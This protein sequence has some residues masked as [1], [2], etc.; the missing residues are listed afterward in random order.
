MRAVFILT[1]S[2]LL[3]HTSYGCFNGET[4]F[5]KDRF[6]FSVNVGGRIPLGHELLYSQDENLI[7]RKMKKYDSLYHVTKDLDYL[8]DMGLLYILQKK[9]DKAIALYLDIEKIQP[10]RYS[11]ASNIGTAYELIGENKEALHWIKKAVEIDSSSHDFSEWIHVNILEAK[12]KGDDYITT[13]HLLNTDFGTESIPT[14]AMTKVEL[15]KLYQALYY[16][17]NERTTFITPK[18]KIVAQLY[19]D[20]GNIELLLGNYGE[21][22]DNYRHAQRY[23]MEDVLL[24]DRMKELTSKLESEIQQR[25]EAKKTKN[26]N[27]GAFIGAF[28]AIAIGVAIYLVK[29]K[30]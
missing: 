8:S 14:S 10:N 30:R 27:L 5:L 7:I 28:V 2:L 1:I 17:L 16:Q 6:I 21:A 15:E 23:G 12:I 18:D 26:H 29:V 11:T 19:F 13:Q 20:L 24:A 22:I 3:H 4:K 9:Y 25:I